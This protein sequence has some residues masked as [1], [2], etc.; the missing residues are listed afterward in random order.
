M[1]KEEPLKC[2]SNRE[3]GGES[4]VDRVSIN[5]NLHKQNRA[6]AESNLG[7]SAFQRSSTSAK[8]LTKKHCPIRFVSFFS[9]FFSFFLNQTQ[10]HFRYR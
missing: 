6:E 2:F 9:F 1:L 7:L 5:H 3:G 8:R 4:K 10:G